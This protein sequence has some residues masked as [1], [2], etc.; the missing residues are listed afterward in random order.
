MSAIFLYFFIFFRIVGYLVMN[1]II[2]FSFLIFFF[3]FWLSKPKIL[4]LS[5]TLDYMLLENIVRVILNISTFTNRNH[6]GK[7]RLHVPNVIFQYIKHLCCILS[8]R[9]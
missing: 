2:F 9:L 3:M 8:T 7:K 5:L 1:F 4:A 6:L